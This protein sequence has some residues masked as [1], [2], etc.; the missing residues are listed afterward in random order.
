MNVLVGCET[1]GQ[2]RDAFKRAGHNAI[3]CDLLPADNGGLHRQGDILELIYEGWADLLI[4]HPPCTYISASGTHWCTGNPERLKLLEAALEF[5]R[6]LFKAIAAQRKRNPEFRSCLEN[7]RGCISTRIA[8]PSQFIQ[9]YE[10]GHDASKETHLWL[11]GLPKL[12]PTLSVAPR[13]VCCGKT[14]LVGMPCPNCM[15]ARKALPRWANQTDSGQNNL[16][17]T[18][19]RWK[20]RSATYPGIAQAM[21]DQ[22]GN[23]GAFRRGLF[24]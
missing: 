15:G 17:M 14:I 13:L 9:P 5:V 21:A 20:L 7:P 22:W 24:D 2:V 8:K 18:D 6:K 16:L 1:S 23:P 3:S 10:Y 19:D 11:S 12:R 4:V